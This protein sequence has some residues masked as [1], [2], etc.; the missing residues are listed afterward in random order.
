MPRPMP[1]PPLS[2][3]NAKAASHRNHHH[4]A[5]GSG[6]SG[7]AML[8]GHHPV[9][10]L[11][12]EV[13]GKGP[14]P[15]PR[16]IPTADVAAT[17]IVAATK[18]L[19][20]ETEDAGGP[21]ACFRLRQVLVSHLLEDGTLGLLLHGTSVVGFCSPAAEASGWMLGDQIVE[22]NGRRVAI[23]DE[24]LD[25]FLSAQQEGFPIK[26]SVLRKEAACPDDEHNDDYAAESAL[27]NF[28]GDTD[29][30]DIAGQLQRKFGA[31]GILPGDGGQSSSS[32]LDSSADWQHSS[33]SITDNPYIQALQKR[34][35]EL[36]K[37]SEGWTQEACDTLAT[38]LATQRSDALATLSSSG[39]HTSAF[40]ECGGDDG[41]GLS[42]ECGPGSS[43]DCAPGGI[44]PALTAFS[45]TVCARPCSGEEHAAYEIQPTPRLD[46]EANLDP[47]QFEPA[48]A[49]HWLGFNP[50][51][52]QT[53]LKIQSRR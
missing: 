26:F 18:L 42:A 11:P 48:S 2:E 22:I 36:L 32:G 15:H 1:L 21:P 53:S 10:G 52:G 24:F 39:R 49:R 25:Q 7:Q 23:F 19:E 33:E 47:K 27:D 50:K 44:P 41:E 14:P 38:R 13:E 46:V 3:F 5:L 51:E 31:V 12:Q 40:A 20:E 17:A 37:S 35:S 29:F 9:V 4:G 8:F 45:L 28:F 6:R 43:A 16:Q 34:R 30:G